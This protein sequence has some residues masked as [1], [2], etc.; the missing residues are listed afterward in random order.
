MQY[1][2]EVT[3]SLEIHEDFSWSLLYRKHHVTKELCGILK[4]M[5]SEVD[6]GIGFSILQMGYTDLIVLYCVVSKAK[7]L[8]T[9]ISNAKVCEGSADTRFLNLPNIHKDTLKDATS[10]YKGKYMHIHIYLMYFLSLVIKVYVV[11]CL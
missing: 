8:L 5:L 10:K 6:T 2:P 3:L 9:A 11:L 1:G 4:N 7:D